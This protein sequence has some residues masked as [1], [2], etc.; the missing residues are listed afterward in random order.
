M[1]KTGE[2]SVI[3]LHP[4]IIELQWDIEFVCDDFGGFTLLG[5]RVK[6]GGVFTGDGDVGL[7]FAGDAAVVRAA[8]V[9]GDGA[10]GGVEQRDVLGIAFRK[11]PPPPSNSRL[12]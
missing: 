11:P 4:D 8:L 2:F 10:H 5:P 6:T 1:G 7:G 9:E 3:P 12:P